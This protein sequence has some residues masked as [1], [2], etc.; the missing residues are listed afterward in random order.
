[1]TFFPQLKSFQI[2]VNQIVLATILVKGHM[3]Y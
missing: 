2:T 1:M 3:L